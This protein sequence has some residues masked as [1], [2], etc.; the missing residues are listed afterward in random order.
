MAHVILFVLTNL[1]R[2]GIGA[3]IFVTAA[4]YLSN[5]STMGMIGPDEPRYAWISR[6]MAQS[7]DWL[8]PRLWS[9]P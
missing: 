6:A 9:G 8:I 1:R 2:F 3:A 7:G 5:L 4:L